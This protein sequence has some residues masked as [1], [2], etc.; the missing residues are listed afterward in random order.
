MIEKNT[1]KEL[2]AIILEQQETII[3]LVESIKAGGTINEANI[4]EMLERGYR[5]RAEV[6]KV[7]AKIDDYEPGE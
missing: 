5:I 1:T 4:D 2:V 7:K 3:L 6:L